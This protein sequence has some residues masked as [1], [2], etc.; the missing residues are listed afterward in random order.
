LSIYGTVEYTYYGNKYALKPDSQS[1]F[2]NLG[3]LLQE[4]SNTLKVLILYLRMELQTLE[5]YFRY[6]NPDSG[7][8]DLSFLE[9]FDFQLEKFE[10]VFQHGSM[11]IEDP[12][13]S[14]TLKLTV[15]EDVARLMPLL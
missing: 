9:S 8:L 2:A 13:K 4:D 10:V 6:G 15:E 12:R 7:P 1:C 14:A 11:K 5:I 3:Q